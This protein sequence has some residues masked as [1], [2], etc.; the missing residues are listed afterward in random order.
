MPEKL[1]YGKAYGMLEIPASMGMLLAWGS[2]GKRMRVHVVKGQDC[3][4]K[5]VG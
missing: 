5:S 2:K 3:L 4:Y 1:K